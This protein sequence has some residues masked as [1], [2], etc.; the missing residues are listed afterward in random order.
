M[1]ANGQTFLNETIKDH[2]LPTYEKKKAWQ[3]LKKKNGLLKLWYIYSAKLKRPPETDP[4]RKWKNSPNSRRL[5]SSPPTRAPS[6]IPTKTRSRYKRTKMTLKSFKFHIT[7]SEK[8]KHERACTNVFFPNKHRLKPIT[9][10][11]IKL[12]RCLALRTIRALSAIVIVVCQRR[13]L[14][15]PGDD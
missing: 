15:K 4:F 3:C 12:V 7:F 5:C 9:V 11:P 8:L 2:Q 13:C 1:C 14:V 6:T 10:K